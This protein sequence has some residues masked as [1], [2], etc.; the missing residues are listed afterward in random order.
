MSEEVGI[1]QCGYIRRSGL[2]KARVIKLPVYTVQFKHSE[3]RINE[4]ILISGF[5][6]LNE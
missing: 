1:P 3:S 6:L 5:L 4:K 2:L